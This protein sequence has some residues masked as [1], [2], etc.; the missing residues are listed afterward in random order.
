MQISLSIHLRGRG[1]QTAEQWLTLLSEQRWGD[2]QVALLALPPFA[3]LVQQ[4]VLIQL[5]LSIIVPR[6]SRKWCP[7]EEPS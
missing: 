1:D 3:S 2:L 4:L 5:V 6:G 7:A